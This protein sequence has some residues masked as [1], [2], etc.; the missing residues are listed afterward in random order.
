MVA[1]A[2]NVGH[3]DLITIVLE[4]WQISRAGLLILE[5]HYSSL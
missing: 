5:G 2:K 4:I 1:D 3:V